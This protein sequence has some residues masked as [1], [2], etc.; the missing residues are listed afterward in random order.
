MARTALTPVDVPEDYTIGGVMLPWTASD[1]VNGN[2]VPHTG[3]EILLVRNDNVGAQTATVASIA[4]PFGRTADCVISLAA[5]EYWISQLFPL[6]G[7]QQ[8]DGNLFIDGSAADVMLCVIR[9]P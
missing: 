3:R 5:A 9:L 6:V 8:A 7:W 4:D 1:N 2:S